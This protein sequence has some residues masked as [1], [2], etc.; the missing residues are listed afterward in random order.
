MKAIIQG[1]EKINNANINVTFQIVNDNDEIIFEGTRGMTSVEKDP[2]KVLEE[3]K[4][5]FN[6]VA[7]TTIQEKESQLAPE[8]QK[9][10]GQEINLD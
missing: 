3:I 5:N 7:T 1:I 4:K 9:L 8:L 2:V 10:V 6:N